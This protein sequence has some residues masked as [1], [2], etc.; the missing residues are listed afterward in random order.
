MTL[1]PYSPQTFAAVVSEKAHLNHAQGQAWRA[2]ATSSSA[3]P[4]TFPPCADISDSESALCHRRDKKIWLKCGEEEESQV[5]SLAR[6]FISV[7]VMK[8]ELI[9]L[10]QLKTA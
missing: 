7:N 1:T 4:P 6:S 9:P 8:M 2:A 5:P 3:P 10:P